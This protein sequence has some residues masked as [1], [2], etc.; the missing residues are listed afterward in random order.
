LLFYRGLP[1]CPCQKSHNK[2]PHFAL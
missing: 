2:A 1:R